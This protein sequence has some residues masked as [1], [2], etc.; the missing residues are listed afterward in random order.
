MPIL[1]KDQNEKYYVS[2]L[3][4]EHYFYTT[5]TQQERFLRPAQQQTELE[6][7]VVDSC[8][9]CSPGRGATPHMLVLPST[10]RLCVKCSLLP[11][12]LFFCSEQR[13]HLSIPRPIFV[14]R[15]KCV[16]GLFLF[17]LRFVLWKQFWSCAPGSS[18]SFAVACT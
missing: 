7:H 1:T 10:R 6:R 3:V 2:R 15:Q 13:V 14:L 11:A 17:L 12:F 5:T 16:A 8:C 18:F 4:L 9:S